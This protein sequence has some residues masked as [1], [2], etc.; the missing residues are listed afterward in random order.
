MYLKRGYHILLVLLLSLSGLFPVVHPVASESGEGESYSVWPMYG[1]GPS[2]RFYAPVDT[3]KNPGYVRWY[4]DAGSKVASSPVIGPDGNLYFA[5]YDG[6]VYSLEPAGVLRWKY[7]TGEFITTPTTVDRF[8]NV[9]VT[10]VNGSVIS[11]SSEGLPRWVF[12]VTGSVSTGVVV[13]ENNMLYFGTNRGELY[14]ITTS[15]TL[16]WNV[17]L[18]AAIVKEIT[19]ANTGA[20]IVTTEYPSIYALNIMGEV[21]WAHNFTP[22]YH[23]YTSGV[24]SPSGSILFIHDFVLYAYDVYGEQ[25]MAVRIPRLEAVH[26]AVSDNG[27]IYVA[28]D[29]RS[30]AMVTPMG[31]IAWVVNVRSSIRSIAVSMDGTIY[32]GTYE[33]WYIYEKDTIFAYY[34]NG[35]RKW[36]MLSPDFYPEGGPTSITIGPDGTIYSAASNYVFAVSTSPPSPPRNVRRET[37]PGYVNISWETPWFDGGEK[38]TSYKVYRYVNNREN[39]TLLATV[40]AERRYY[41]DTEVELGVTYY[42]FVTALNKVGESKPSN[43][44]NATSRDVPT[45]PLNLTAS[46][47]KKWIVLSWRPP[48]SE[49]GA[50]ILYYRIY[51]REGYGFFTL[52]AAIEGDKLFFNDTS[53]KNG[54]TYYYYVGATNVVGESLPSNVVV[55]TIDIPSPPENLTARVVEGY[56]ELEW[57][58]PSCTGAS[59]VLHYH[60]FRGPERGLECYYATVPAES[61]SFV[62]NYIDRGV[63]YYYYVVAENS[64]GASLPSNYVNATGTSSVRRPSA[65]Q[66]LTAKVVEDRYVLL[67][68]QPP[69]DDGGGRIIN[70]VLYRGETEEVIEIYR[71]V[72]GNKTIFKDTNVKVGNTYYYYVAAVNEGGKSPKSETV[73]IKVE[74]PSQKERREEKGQISMSVV[75]GSLIVV[76]VAVALILLFMKGK[77]SLKGKEKL[78][79]LEEDVEG[80]PAPLGVVEG[81]PEEMPGEREEGGGGEEGEVEEKREE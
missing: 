74:P 47:G 60:I 3:S 54:E 59:P 8:G 65:P 13:D 61:T 40:G 39:K 41:N 24:V 45:P 28:V 42:Y 37:G 77:F 23:R 1:G 48:T 11:L 5:T 26:P 46:P 35:T 32:V 27:S 12:P 55:A 33:G 64:Y 75:A 63:V 15:G 21:M 38:I 43:I 20:L 53:V 25:T 44:V 10:T 76:L 71:M 34:P 7:Y 81:S 68:W 78:P 22:S 51:R 52:L 36:E 50:E 70:Y 62:D 30:L 18:N 16:L 9:Y 67:S 17:T 29:K 56:I 6:T 2:R 58:P 19:V 57:E 73:M 14:S 31:E 69:A 72:G 4:F 66:N 49:G 79:S 80:I